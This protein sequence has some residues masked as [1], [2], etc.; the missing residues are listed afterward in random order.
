MTRA[1]ADRMLGFDGKEKGGRKGIH[2][3]HARLPAVHAKVF[4]IVMKPTN[5]IPDDREEGPTT[6]S[7]VVGKDC[8]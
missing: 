4:K 6:S 3:H 7:G 5:D 8:N 2:I 1:V